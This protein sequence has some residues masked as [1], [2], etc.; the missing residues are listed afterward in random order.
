MTTKP[1]KSASVEKPKPSAKI[2]KSLELRAKSAEKA[3]DKVDQKL[4]QLI[5]AVQPKSDKTI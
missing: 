3:A 5:K 4:K 2:N 1:V